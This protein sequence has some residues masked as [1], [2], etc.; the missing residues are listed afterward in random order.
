MLTSKLN[1][2]VA[3]HLHQENV[4][5]NLVSAQLLHPT[6]PNDILYYEKLITSIFLT[7]DLIEKRRELKYEG[8]KKKRVIVLLVLSIANTTQL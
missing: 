2:S 7:W 5:L 4:N 8:E 6:L 1:N 3:E